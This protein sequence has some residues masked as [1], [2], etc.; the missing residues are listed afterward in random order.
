MLN[1]RLDE[2]QS[3]IKIAGKILTVSYI[4]MIPLNG[5]KQRECKEP[6]DEGVRGK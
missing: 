4:Q 2:P 6:V 5:R 3:G 1:A